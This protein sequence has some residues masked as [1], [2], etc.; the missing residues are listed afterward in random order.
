M[1]IRRLDLTSLG[2]D[3]QVFIKSKAF[4]KISPSHSEKTHTIPQLK[5]TVMEGSGIYHQNKHSL[6]FCSLNILMYLRKVTFL[7]AY[8]TNSAN[9]NFGKFHSAY[10]LFRKENKQFLP[11]KCPVYLITKAAK[12]RCS[13][14]TCD[15]EVL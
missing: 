10:K 6:L 12:R 8:L 2:R 4:L 15:N 14:L 7:Y 1:C 5:L 13:L 9:V 3:R 11:T